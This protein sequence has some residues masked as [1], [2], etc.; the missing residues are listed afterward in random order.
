M[1]ASVFWYT[2]DSAIIVADQVRRRPVAMIAHMTDR[3]RGELSWP[4]FTPVKSGPFWTAA[5]CGL[6]ADIDK[7]FPLIHIVTIVLAADVK[8]VGT[9]YHF[10]FA[11]QDMALPRFM[12][13]SD[14]AADV[15]VAGAIRPI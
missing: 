15:V 14:D 13:R 8:H 9:M 1:D 3:I 12:Q 2:P 5:V 6:V 4:P 11:T 7:L 10:P